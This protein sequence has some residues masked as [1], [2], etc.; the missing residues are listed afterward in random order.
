M[1]NAYSRKLDEPRLIE[2]FLKTVLDFDGSSPSV[3]NKLTRIE[4]K[5]AQLDIEKST[6]NDKSKWSKP[7]NTVVKRNELRNI[8]GAELY[9]KTRLKDDDQI[10]LG[11]GGCKPKN[12]VKNERKAFIIIG[13]PAAGK[14]GIANKI[15]DLTHSYILDNDYAKRK[16]PEFNKS[17]IGA[18]L[19]HNESDLI[20]FGSN[21]IRSFSTLTPLFFQCVQKKHNI[22]IPKIG[23]N[24]NSII[25]LANILTENC[26]YKVHLVLVNLNRQHATKRALERYIRSNRYVPLSLIFDGYANDPTITYFRL[27]E[28]RENFSSF[29]EI[30][31]TTKPYQKNGEKA[32]IVHKINN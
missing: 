22:V 20:V 6:H 24:K 26:G 11:Y 1:S 8:I 27:K 2:H 5:L 12:G 3:I 17:E 13:L 32:S 14:S 31:T 23:A 15:A 21:S 25:E 18:S 10:R 29:G 16:L 4:K 7:F 9:K 30:D 28:S 19:T